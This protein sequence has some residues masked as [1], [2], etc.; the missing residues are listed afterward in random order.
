M[1]DYFTPMKYVLKEITPLEK[2]SLFW[3]RYHPNHRLNFPL[4]YHDEYELCLME[5]IYGKRT[6]GNLVEDFGKSDLVLIGP[7]VLHCYKRG[8][9]YKDNV[10]EGIII[11]FGKNLIHTEILNTY[12]F[13][14][15][16]TMLE[17][18]AVGI[19][20]SAETTTKVREKLYCLVNLQDFSAVTLFFEILNE[21]ALSEDQRILI[22][23]TL[24]DCGEINIQQSRR[25]NK[26]I[27]F[28][29]KN[30]QQKITL[31]QIGELIGMS[32]SSVSRF[33][34]QRTRHR[35]WDY[36][37]NFRVKKAT[38]ILM[39]TNHSISEICYECGFNNISNFNRVFKEK[40][41][42]TPS[43]Y[44]K[45]IQDSTVPLNRA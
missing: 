28:V 34:K 30:Y 19:Q 11:Q 18:A 37:N 32:P 23:P 26:I 8:E 14:D 39:E 43:E 2:N 13:R 22:P 9:D 20:F 42:Y 7:D 33:F 41:Q 6:V 27:Q 38:K 45:K 15:I 1:N 17:K 10:C 5:H 44:R 12:Q 21:L 29:E 40:M 16:K 36:L 24:E 3:I 25:I 4:H 31:E 35:F